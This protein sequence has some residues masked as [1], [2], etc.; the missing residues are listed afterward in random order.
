MKHWIIFVCLLG[1]GLLGCTA[2]DDS[3]SNTDESSSDDVDLSTD[4]T[5]SG[6][7]DTDS[8]GDECSVIVADGDCDT[9]LRPIVF[10]HGTYGSGDNIGNVALLFASNGFCADRFIAVEYNS[11]GGNPLDPLDALIDKVRA[12][13]GF[14]QVELMGHSQG[15]RHSIDYLAEADHAA[16]VAHY[17]HL[18]GDRV[19]PEGVPTLSISSENDINGE[20]RHAEGAETKITLKDDDHFTLAASLDAF[21]EIYKY[22]I[23]KEPQYT[24]IQCGEDPVTLEAVAETFGDNEPVAGGKFEVY[25]LG[26]SP[27]ERGTPIITLTTD[28][29]GHIAPFELKRLTSYEFKGFDAEGNLLGYLYFAPFKRTN[30]LLRFLTPSNDPVVTALTTD[31]VTTS[32][33]HSSVVGRSLKGA[34]RHDMGQSLKVNGSDVL[35]DD[36]AGRANMSVGLFM[37]DDK[38]DGASDLGVVFEAPFVFGTDVYMDAS[39]PAWIEFDW[40]GQIMKIPNWPSTEGLISIMFP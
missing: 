16:K 22:L 6:E 14:D 19:A 36:N 29:N 9:S 2:D 33:D 24:K 8:D 11:L 26:E 25:E 30:R 17:V 4:D 3:E 39:A 37:F 23:G 10:V 38:I 40:N 35:T 15:T 20:P 21:I 34:F 32:P 1:F 18:S 12:E 27:N 31:R 28:A 13:T 5:D 7:S